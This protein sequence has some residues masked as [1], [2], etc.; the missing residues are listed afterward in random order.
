[1]RLVIHVLVEVCVASVPVNIRAQALAGMLKAA[2]FLEQD[3]LWNAVEVYC[4]EI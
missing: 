3:E 4:R 2:S 1:M